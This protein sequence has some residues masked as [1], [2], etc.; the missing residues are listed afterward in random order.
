MKLL[1]GLGLLGAGMFAVF[2]YSGAFYSASGECEKT[3]AKMQDCTTMAEVLAVAEPH[4]V[5]IYENFPYTLSSGATVDD[6]KP[7]P[8]IDFKRATIEQQVKDGTLAGGLAFIYIYSN[9]DSFEVKFDATGNVVYVQEQE[10]IR[11]MPGN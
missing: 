2:Y 4:K 6:W 11:G 5:S 1:L 8:E 3:M 7:G 9:A 10:G